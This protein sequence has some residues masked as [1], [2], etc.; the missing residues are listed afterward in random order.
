MPL[1]HLATQKNIPLSEFVRPGMAIA[2]LVRM[3]FTEVYQVSRANESGLA[4]AARAAEA[5]LDRFMTEY[6]GLLIA[7]R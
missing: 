2:I 1:A 3:S 6:V 5:R 7:R 4:I